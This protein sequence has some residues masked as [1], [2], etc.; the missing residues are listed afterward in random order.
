MPRV[1]AKTSAPPPLSASGADPARV[2]CAPGFPATVQI[3]CP[4]CQHA[5]TVIVS[6]P[7]LA[8]PHRPITT[9]PQP[10][11]LTV[12]TPDP[13]CYSLCRE[14]ACWV[15]VLEGKRAHLKHE[16]GLH[17]VNYL[18]HHPNQAVSGATLFSKFHL[19]SPETSGITHLAL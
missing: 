9:P 6:T 8:N 5:I 18:M 2:R 19:Q 14:P 1:P 16:I 4:C 17:Y 15:L 12:E 10:L 3:M 11:P 13:S 7:V